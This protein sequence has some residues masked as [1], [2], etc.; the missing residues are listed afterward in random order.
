M[1]RHLLPSSRQNGTQLLGRNLNGNVAAVT[2]TTTTVTRASSTTITADDL[3]RRNEQ[4]LAEASALTRSLYRLCMRSAKLIRQGNEA[5]ATEF[6]AREEKQIRDMTEVA[7]DE[8]LS[9]VVSMLPPV[10]PQAELQARSEY[11]AQY[12]NENFFAESDGLKTSDDV[13]DDDVAAIPDEGMFAR[14]FYHLRKGEEHRKWLLE[15]MKFEDPYQFDL[16]RV[17][18]LE[19]RVR[20][21]LQF[22][23]SYRWQQLDPQQRQAIEQAQLDLDTYDSDE[24]A[25]SD[26]EEDDD[27][28]P[29][30]RHKN[31]NRRY[32][33]D[34]EDD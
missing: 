2:S 5:D 34:E 24:E 3:R 4:V 1:L 10:E 20:D 33:E 22:Q 26:E 28:E 21:L 17:D 25:F 13:G 8:R 23:A 31:R 15:D 18:R 7:G 6:A 30:I 19:A 12:T 16:E 29:P 27:S 32:E 14:Y 11:Y 9:G